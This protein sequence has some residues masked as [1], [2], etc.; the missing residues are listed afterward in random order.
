MH[1]NRQEISLTKIKGILPQHRSGIGHSKMVLPTVVLNMQFS[2]M[3]KHNISNILGGPRH[4][5]VATLQLGS[6]NEIVFVIGG[7]HMRNRIK[8]SKCQKGWGPLLLGCDLRVL[9]TFPERGPPPA[10]KS[11]SMKMAFY[12][13]YW[14]TSPRDSSWWRLS[15]LGLHRQCW[16]ESTRPWG[17]S[18][19]RSSMLSPKEGGKP[20]YCWPIRRALDSGR[21]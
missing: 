2:T 11:R 15:C 13:R 3:G 14:N 7:Y 18:R 16:R 20:E 17:E 21:D 1:I 9:K 10:P 8:G 4:G 12:D 6:S 5:S 19:P